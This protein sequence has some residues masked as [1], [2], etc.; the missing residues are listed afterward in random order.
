MPAADAESGKGD[1]WRAEQLGV[2]SADADVDA[3]SDVDSTAEPSAASGVSIA[4]RMPAPADLPP[5]EPA[6]DSYDR[7]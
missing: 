6:G 1:D 3:G 7:F 2:L 4:E 5:G